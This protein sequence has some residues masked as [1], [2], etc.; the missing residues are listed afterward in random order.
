MKK[1]FVIGMV[2]FAVCSCIKSLAKKED[3]KQ[4]KDTKKECAGITENNV[5]DGE[6]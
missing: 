2:I 5:L 3:E 4:E 6:N 1:I